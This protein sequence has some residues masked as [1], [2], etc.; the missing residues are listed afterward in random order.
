VGTIVVG[1]LVLVA[2]P[3]ILALFPTHAYWDDEDQAAY[4]KAS[5]EAH[6]AA[7]GGEHDHSQ[8][9]TH[10]MPVDSKAEAL[11]IST[12]AEFERHQARLLAAQSSQKWLGIAFRVLGLLLAVGGV[13]L[14]VRARR[15]ESG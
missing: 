8:P 4:E 15:A 14:F 6:A 11:R 7:F 9:H 10:E 13:L 2:G 5:T 3:L 1:L 12:R